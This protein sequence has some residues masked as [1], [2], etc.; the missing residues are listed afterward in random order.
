MKWGTIG[1]VE[2]KSD[3]YIKAQLCPAICKEYEN[4]L[5]NLMASTGRYYSS[6]GDSHEWGLG[7]VGWGW[8]GG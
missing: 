7:H 5:S 4:E 8:I 3:S 1:S 2:E 6:M